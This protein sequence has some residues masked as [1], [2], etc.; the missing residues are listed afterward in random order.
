MENNQETMIQATQMMENNQEIM[1]HH[2]PDDGEQPGDNDSSSNP[3][4][5]EKPGDNDSGKPDTGNN[6]GN[7][8]SG[9][10]DDG[11]N[12]P[13]DSGNH[14]QPPKHDGNL[15]RI[16]VI[17][18]QILDQMDQIMVRKIIPI[19]IQIIIV[20]S[21]G[22]H[23]GHSST[24]DTVKPNKPVFNNNNGSTNGNHSTGSNHHNNSVSD[25]IIHQIYP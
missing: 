2:N 9:E 1:I 23:S 24:N 21:P 3:D 5:G 4:D 19:A 18:I 8:D 14:Q 11:G 22:N 25:S 20:I 17:I 15:V 13:G 6:P 7:N 12:K 10:Q 16:K